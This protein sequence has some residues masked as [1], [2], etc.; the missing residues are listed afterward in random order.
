MISVADNMIYRIS[1]ANV[2]IFVV[3]VVVA[4][5]SMQ[6][7]RELAFHLFFNTHSLRDL[8]CR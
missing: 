8:R 6:A 3:V 2:V 5:T 1:V 4:S 7:G